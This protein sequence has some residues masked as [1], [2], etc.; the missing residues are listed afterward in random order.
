MNSNTTVRKH[1]SPP[2]GAYSFQAV[3]STGC[4]ILDGSGA[5]IAW[6]VD[7]RVASIVAG[8]LNVAC[9]ADLIAD[10]LDIFRPLN[11]ENEMYFGDCPICKSNDGY[12]NVGPTHWFVCHAHKKRWRAGSGLFSAWKHEDESVWQENAEQIKDYEEVE[13]VYDCP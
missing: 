2:T 7:E 1:P 10:S 5:V 9:A 4:E 3:G 13:P 12:L 11:E 6:T 8:L